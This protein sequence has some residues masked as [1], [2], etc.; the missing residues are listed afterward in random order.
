MQ[1]FLSRFWKQES[2]AITVDWVVLTAAMAGFGVAVASIIVTAAN[3]PAEG[4]GAVLTD[5]EVAS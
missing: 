1:Q 2:G 4:M 5:I 3:D